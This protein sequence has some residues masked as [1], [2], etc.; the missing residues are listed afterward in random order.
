M[1]SLR[2]S[3]HVPPRTRTKRAP[4][5]ALLL[6]LALAFFAVA[7]H[8]HK[9]SDSYLTLN[10]DGD[11]ISGR[12][13]IAVRD[14]EYAIG[15]D[16]NNDGN[17]TWGELRAQAPAIAA[18]A[19]ARL[20][21]ARAQSACP[22]SVSSQQI[23]RHS[24][25]A[26]VVLHLTGQCTAAG[27]LALQ[28]ALLFD[29]DP[30][31]KGLA[32]VRNGAAARDVV[33]DRTHARFVS[34]GADADDAGLGAT[35]T[36]YLRLG[37]WH[38]ATGFDHLLFLLALLLP[39]VL[40]RVDGKLVPATRLA[41]V[42]RATV[43]IV[44]AFTLAHSLTLSLAALQVVVLPSRW[45]ES[46]IAASVIFAALNNVIPMV[47]RRLWLLAFGFGLIHGMGFA[48][49]LLDLGLPVEA[50]A[51][52]LLAFNVGVEAGQLLLVGLFF[53]LAY[54]LRHTRFYRWVAFAEG[55]VVIAGVAAVWLVER[56]FDLR[57]F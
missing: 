27:P 23:D 8:A 41:P 4:T 1:N 12:W 50:R 43:K 37:V 28:Y 47:T 22:L 35:F 32:R 20:Q 2:P 24:D 33:F 14:L 30:Q 13:D 48:G 16:G 44:T 52:A 29:V 53:A 5:L 56:A 38:I 31:H 6:M 49:V 7:A 3:L 39:T 42:M 51:L 40:L 55:S 57:V 18:Y 21:V 15:V 25:G 46:A 9:P 10:A 11:R 34:S 19:L 45:V 26:Y 54:P 17:V 36:Q